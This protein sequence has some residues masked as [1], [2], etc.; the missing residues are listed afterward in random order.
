MPIAIDITESMQNGVLKAVETGQRLTVDAAKVAAA[1]LDGFWPERPA[2]PFADSLP[3][4]QEALDSSFR[5]AERLLAAQR[6]FVSE[7]ASLTASPA[8]PAAPAK[9]APVP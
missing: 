6:S 2:T 9:K 8:A 4:A 7:L 1:T 3:T 5:F